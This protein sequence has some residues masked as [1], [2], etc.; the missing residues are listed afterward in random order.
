MI[1]SG[2][3]YLAVSR[4]HIFQAAGKFLPWCLR[5]W[6]FVLGAWQRELHAG[7]RWAGN[8]PLLSACLWHSV[9]EGLI[10]AQLCCFLLSSLHLWALMS[11]CGFEK[12]SVT[13]PSKC[14]SGCCL[15]KEQHLKVNS[16]IPWLLNWYVFLKASNLQG[17]HVLSGKIKQ[18]I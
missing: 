11:P 7:A 10:S 2:F 5:K 14:R 15:F 13:H 16:V 12:K 17:R 9:L 3:I 6:G 18:D 1:F 4:V 8:V